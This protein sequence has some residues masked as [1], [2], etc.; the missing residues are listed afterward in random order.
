VNYWTT[1][2]KSER[3]V[4]KERSTNRSERNGDPK[5]KKDLLPKN[6]PTNPTRKEAKT[7]KK[8]FLATV[9]RLSLASGRGKKLTEE[10]K[11]LIGEEQKKKCTRRLI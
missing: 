7:G 5:G 8:I 9:R 4:A 1:K 10:R 6:T 3:K 2:L 11:G